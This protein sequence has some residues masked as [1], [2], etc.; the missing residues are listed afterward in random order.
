[1]ARRLQFFLR[2]KNPVRVC[3]RTSRPTV[4]EQVPSCVPTSVPLE[5]TKYSSSFYLS[6]LSYF[7]PYFSILCC[8]CMFVADSFASVLF[9]SILRLSTRPLY[10]VLFALTFFTTFFLS[11]ALLLFFTVCF[12]PF[13][14][15]HMSFLNSFSV[16]ATS[17]LSLRSMSA[18]SV[19]NVRPVSSA[20]LVPFCSV[21]NAF[22]II[23]TPFKFCRFDPV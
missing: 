11:F 19:A 17:S 10:S 8:R 1:V 12:F 7:I 15:S 20:F 16:R 14:C 9:Q 13:M 6:I 4:P 23:Y 5:R 21:H 2:W 22:T 3:V 18:K